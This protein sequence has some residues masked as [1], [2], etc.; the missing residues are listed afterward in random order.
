[1]FDKELIER[2]KSV[3]GTDFVRL[4]YTDGVDILMKSGVNLSFLFTGVLICRV[5]MKDTLLKSISKPVIL[6]DY[7]KEIKAFYMKQNEDGKTVR[8]MDV[9]FLKLVK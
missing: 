8:A 6:T 3:V 1:M 4:S 5:N 9:L 7:P 2:L